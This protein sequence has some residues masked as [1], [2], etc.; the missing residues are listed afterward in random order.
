ML[1]V[2]LPQ[3]FLDEDVTIELTEDFPVV[4]GRIIRFTEQYIVLEGDKREY[5]I[6]WTSI[7][8]IWIAHEKIAKKKEA[9]TR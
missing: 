5:V 9:V 7:A 2:S 4:G 8:Y 6:P 1:T 3:K